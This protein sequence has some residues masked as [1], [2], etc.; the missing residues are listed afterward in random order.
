MSRAAT[1]RKPT[2]IVNPELLSDDGVREQVA[3]Q[4]LDIQ[5]LWSCLPPDNTILPDAG[6]WILVRDV[7][8]TVL[9]FEVPLY[10]IWRARPVVRKRGVYIGGQ[11]SDYGGRRK[12]VQWPQ[13]LAEIQTPGGDL[14]L[15]PTEYVVTDVAKWLELLDDGVTLHFIG[16]GEPG[17]LSETLFYM[18]AH[19]LRRR[20][21]L[22]LLLP[23]LTD[24]R[25]AYLTLDVS[26][27]C[28]DN[29]SDSGGQA[30]T[31]LESPS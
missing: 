8:H 28:A 14:V 16:A 2:M 6:A 12:L 7:P 9:P 24:E 5:T 19:G 29:H 20:D 26:G 1:S 18:R 11:H 17:D 30:K 10:S 27:S 25:F 22:T 3:D 21:A 15:Y 13:M 31:R 23:Q 4:C